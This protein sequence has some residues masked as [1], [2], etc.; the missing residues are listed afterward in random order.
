MGGPTPKYPLSG[1]CSVVHEETLYVYSPLGFQS[2]Q[3]KEGAE[4]EELSMDISLTGGKCVKVVPPGDASG[5][6]LYIVGGAVNDTAASWEYPG[7][8]HYSFSQKKWDWLRAETWVTKDRHSHDAAYLPASNSLLVYSGSRTPGNFEPS[9]E[10]FTISLE[11]PYKVSSGPPGDAPLSVKPTLMSWTDSKAVMVGGS[12]QNS[13][14]YTFAVGEGWRNLGVGLQAPITNPDA[15]QCTTVWGDDGSRVL[16]MFDMSKSPNEITRIA[17]LN[18]GGTV[19][20]PGTTVG[21]KVKRV[22]IQDWPSYNGTLAPA[23]TRTGYSIASDENGVAVITGGSD[24]DPLCIFNQKSNA[25]VNATQLFAGEQVVIQSSP[26]G[27]PSSTILSTPSGGTTPTAQASPSA[28]PAVP[29]GAALNSKSRMLTV[30]GATLGAI[31]GIAAILILLLFCLKYRKSKNKNQQ[32]TGYIEKD[33]LSFADRGAEFMS[34]AGGSIGHKFTERNV[35]HTSLAIIGNGPTTHKR[36]IGS[37]ASTAGLVVRKGPLGYSDPVEM[38]KFDLKPEPIE[39]RMIR[40]NS[41]R[42]PRT[43]AAGPGRSRSSGWSRYFANNEATNLAN[44][45][46]DRSTYA[47]ERTSTGSQSMYTNSRMYSQPSQS[48]PPL[49]IPKFD[50]QR[51]SRVATGSPTYSQENLPSQPM[52]AELARANS[53]G[54][55]ASGLS[56]DDDYAPV[57]SWTPMGNFEE[58]RP[59]SSAYTGSVVMDNPRDGVNSYYADGTSSHYPKSGYSSIFPGGAR[60]GA[61]EGRESTVTVFPGVQDRKQNPQPDMS[62]LNLGAGK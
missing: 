56:R 62:W 18:Q 2:L 8:M 55:T 37:D 49:D 45:P 27:T 35:S 20:A 4:W 60:F 41:G 46:S 53:K 43:A 9:S 40:Q 25:W 22:T 23:A 33:R 30:L 54:S 24:E 59:P 52:Q 42:V 44:M 61:P 15:V 58:N 50:N 38:S 36:G 6:K 7:L 34:E 13:A 10:T 31:F 11:Q 1:H 47:S 16:E 5:A 32:Q 21:D 3:L 29:A 17:L 48:V 12:A 39:E 19:A 26:S 14:V 28:E 57:E 51:I